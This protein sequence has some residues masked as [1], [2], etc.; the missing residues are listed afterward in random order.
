MIAVVGVLERALRKSW[1]IKVSPPLFGE[2]LGRLVSQGDRRNISCA[3]E[4]WNSKARHALWIVL[5]RNSACDG[6]ALTSKKNSSIQLLTTCTPLLYSGIRVL[7]KF[8]IDPKTWWVGC[9]IQNRTFNQWLDRMLAKK[10]EVKLCPYFRW[11]SWFHR[12][13]ILLSVWHI[14][15]CCKTTRTRALYHSTFIF[16]LAIWA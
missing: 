3:A 6:R 2:S 5:V 16:S 4:G 14:W 15:I 8:A 12:L 11:R 7:S 10:I 1:R 13:C 9:R